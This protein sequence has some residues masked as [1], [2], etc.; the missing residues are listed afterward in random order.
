MLCQYAGC[1][2]KY[3]NATLAQLRQMQPNFCCSTANLKSVGVCSTSSTSESWHHP[4]Q[5]GHCE[6]ASCIPAAD[7]STSA[8]VAHQHICDSSLDLEL[9]G[10][11]CDSTQELELRGCG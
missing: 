1:I 2:L 3:Y 8:G 4:T 7:M 11:V 9:Q 6:I 10:C 5:D